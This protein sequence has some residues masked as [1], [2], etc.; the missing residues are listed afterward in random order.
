MKC[1]KCKSENIEIITHVHQNGKSGDSTTAILMLIS[2]FGSIVSGIA[3]REAIKSA[4]SAH[5]I[6]TQSFD[7]ICAAFCLRFL[8]DI[9]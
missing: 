3:M 1:P 5:E 2:I 7:Y 4:E 8:F 9:I 6:I